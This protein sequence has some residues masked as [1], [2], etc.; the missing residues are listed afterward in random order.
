MGLCGI[1]KGGVGEIFGLMNK[2]KVVFFSTFCCPPSRKRKLSS[3]LKHPLAISP[4]SLP[5]P[6]QFLILPSNLDWGQ[7]KCGLTREISKMGPEER[8]GGRREGVGA[9]RP[10]SFGE[11]GSG[12]KGGAEA[13]RWWTGGWGTKAFTDFSLFQKNSVVVGGLPNITLV[14]GVGVRVKLN[15]PHASLAFSFNE[16]ALCVLKKCLRDQIGKC[17]K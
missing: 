4:P 1:V 5:L 13:G 6:H 14:I 2:K 15:S 7:G 12:L 17:I 9:V 10:R 8:D 11:A 16:L 3:Y